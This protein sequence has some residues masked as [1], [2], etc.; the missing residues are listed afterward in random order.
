MI[1][2]IQSITEITQKAAKSTEE[3]KRFSDDG[4]K[5]KK[6]LLLKSKRFL[7]TQQDYKKQTL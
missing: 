4:R 6:K 5:N 7:K 1:G 3:L 2:G